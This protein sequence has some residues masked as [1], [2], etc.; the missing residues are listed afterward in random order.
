MDA[1]F[2]IYRCDVYVIYFLVIIFACLN[3]SLLI[4]MLCIPCTMFI[5]NMSSEPMS[6][7]PISSIR[8]PIYFLYIYFY[9]KL[10]LISKTHNY[11]IYKS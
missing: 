3:R 9:F 5:T 2:E 4:C 11:T 8:N 7:G 1:E 6:L 10:Y